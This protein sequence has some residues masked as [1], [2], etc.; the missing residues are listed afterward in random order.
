M[1]SSNKDVL[2]VEDLAELMRIS[3]NTIQSKRWQ[4]K[5][6]CPIFKKG[7]RLYAETS[8][9]SKWFRGGAVR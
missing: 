8:E 7:K 5:S 4:K 1:V 6:G 2:V 9:F 3:P